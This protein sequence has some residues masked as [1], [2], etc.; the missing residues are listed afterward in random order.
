M[1]SSSVWKH[2]S[3]FFGVPIYLNMQGKFINF[4]DW[5]LFLNRH[6]EAFFNASRSWKNTIGVKNK[7]KKKQNLH[8]R[9]FGVCCRRGRMP[10]IS[11]LALHHNNTRSVAC[12]WT[13]IFTPLCYFSKEKYLTWKRWC[14]QLLFP[15]FRGPSRLS[16]VP[17]LWVKRWSANWHFCDSLWLC[18]ILECT[19]FKPRSLHLLVFLVAVSSGE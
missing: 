11:A 17:Y 8:L 14:N 12:V 3:L 9:C 16:I 7:K 2:N 4:I 13:C 15:L 10:L 18:A 1:F 5:E 6:L 19:H